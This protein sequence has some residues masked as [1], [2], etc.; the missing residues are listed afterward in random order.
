MKSIKLTSIYRL[1]NKIKRDFDFIEIDDNK[2][3]EWVGE[4]LDALGTNVQYA[5][6]VCYKAV[7]N[8]QLEMPEWSSALIQILRYNGS[9]TQQNICN[10][11]SSLADTSTTE[12][13]ASESANSCCTGVQDEA[14]NVYVSMEDCLFTYAISNGY[15]DL[16][17]R[18][19]Y[20]ESNTWTPVRLT[21]DKFFND[22]VCKIP[23]IPPIYKS[24]RD[25]YTIIAGD[26]IRFNFETGFVAIA[27]LGYQLDDNG[28]PLIPDDYSF[29]TAIEKYIIMKISEREFYSGRQGGLQRFQKSEADWHFYV[30][31][32]KNKAM[33]ASY[34]EAENLRQQQDYILPRSNIYQNHSGTI[35]YK[36]TRLH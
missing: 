33:I 9:I 8:Y 26:T 11:V 7:T 20:G 13:E 23:N 19:S 2:I 29:L 18:I 10:T 15:T 12:E 5:E 30:R 34:D 6:K 21:T 16:L 22:K 27:Y 28:Y 3:I 25:E 1:I 17:N 36:Q 24:C 4:S 35:N 32:S 31:Q 14:T